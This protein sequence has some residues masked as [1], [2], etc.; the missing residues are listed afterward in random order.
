MPRAVPSRRG[1]GTDSSECLREIYDSPSSPSPFSCSSCSLP[2]AFHASPH[3]DPLRYLHQAQRDRQQ[4]TLSSAPPSRPPSPSVSLRH[5]KRLRVK[6]ILLL[7]GDRVATAA[8]R[9]PSGR[10]GER[11][12][13]RTPR[14]PT[15]PCR[16]HA[17]THA[18][19]PLARAHPRAY[20]T[21]ADA[22]HRGGGS[23]KSRQTGSRVIRY[24]LPGSAAA[25]PRWPSRRPA[26]VHRS[27]RDSLLAGCW[28]HAI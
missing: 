26:S 13:F 16:S 10:E 20:Y 22:V 2:G 7:K 24:L 17:H 23:A 11:P 9:R 28:Q 27:A 25:Q 19:P 12:S 21:R 4:E 5:T 6:G 3:P 18:P 1:P 15:G 14:G 8:P